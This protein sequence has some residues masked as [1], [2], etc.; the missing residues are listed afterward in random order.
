M[1]KA[2]ERYFNRMEN[3]ENLRLGYCGELPESKTLQ[4][5]WIQLPSLCHFSVRGVDLEW[6]SWASDHLETL[7]IEDTTPF[8]N[9]SIHTWAKVLSYFPLLQ[10]LEFN[11]ADTANFAEIGQYGPDDRPLARH[12]APFT[13]PALHSLTLREVRP[14]HLEQVFLAIG[15]P[16]LKLLRLDTD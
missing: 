11:L 9:R 10:K 1:T 13:L 2:G 12:P 16:S 8:P 5:Y 15:M 4:N 6:G 3:L 14:Y 7:E